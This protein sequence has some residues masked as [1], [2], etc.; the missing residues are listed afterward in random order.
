MFRLFDPYAMAMCFL[1]GGVGF[2]ITYY[3]N[4][5]VSEWGAEEMVYP[6]MAMIYVYARN[7]RF[8]ESDEE[9]ATKILEGHGEATAASTKGGKS[10]GASAA[11]KA[12][13]EGEGPPKMQ[14]P[15]PEGVPGLVAVTG[16]PL[17]A[18]AEGSLAVVF[19]F[20][21]WCVTCEKVL[22]AILSVAARYSEDGVNFAGVAK[23]G[24]DDVRYFVETY[25]RPM[26]SVT[27]LADEQG[28][29]TDGYQGAH[30][31]KTIPHCYIVRGAASGGGTGVVVWHGHP[32]RLEAALCYLM[33]EGEEEGRG[34]DEA[35]PKAAPLKG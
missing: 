6:V 34:E 17:S 1:V 8:F 13:V 18:P 2:G 15:S 21:T 25:Q 23:E 24:E 11:S 7:A 35:A 32:A 3:V 20:A 5:E 16:P 14:A 26:R 33:D 19:F 28:V 29:L 31:T 22:P 10:G 9:S 12:A 30:K 4:T 27:I